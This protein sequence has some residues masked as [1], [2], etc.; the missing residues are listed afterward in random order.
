LQL[1]GDGKAFVECV[2]GFVISLGFHLAHTAP[3]GGGW[4]R[5]RHS[6]DARV[7]LGGLTIGRVQCH[8]LTEAVW[9]GSRGWNSLNPR[10][11]PPCPNPHLRR[12]PMSEDT[13]HHIRR[14]NVVFSIPPLLD[15]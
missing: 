5:T 7:R 6:H 8:C 1:L 15:A 4:G 9:R 12:L 13:L 11:V 14:W 2:L 3:C 10:L